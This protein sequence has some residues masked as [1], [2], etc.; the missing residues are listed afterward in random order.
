MESIMSS[1]NPVIAGALEALDQARVALDAAHKRLFDSDAIPD[2][3]D[4]VETSTLVGAVSENMMKLNML[5][6]GRYAAN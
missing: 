1:T 3:D 6:T 2:R 4:L 5:L